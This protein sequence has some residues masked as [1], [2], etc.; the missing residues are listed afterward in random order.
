MLCSAAPLSRREKTVNNAAQLVR[1]IKSWGRELGFQQVGVTG[2][3]LGEA[4]GRLLEWLRRGY[5][6]E[7]NYMARHGA[8]RTR[9]A[10]LKPG[11]LTVISARMDYFPRKARAVAETLRDPAAAFISRYALGAD[12]HKLMR[13]RLQKLA[14]RIEKETGAFC[15]RAFTDSA[16][17]MEKPLAQKAG[18][19]WI[20]KHSN[21]INRHAGS[22]FFLGELYTDLKLPRDAPAADHCGTCDS[23]ITACPTGAI[24]AP[25]VV[26]ARKC[27][28]YL[29]IELKG[30]IPEPLRPL[31]GN[32]VFGCDDCQAVCPWNRFAQ[33]GGEHAFA[34][35]HGLDSAGLIALFAWSEEEFLRRT[36]GS[37]IRRI[38]YEQWLRNLAVALGNAPP[39]ATVTAALRSREN[40]PAPLV[41]EHVAWALL[42]TATCR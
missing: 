39:S 9:P 41:R 3:E 18:L 37:A 5:H 40:H 29:T 31:L 2:T 17:V 35:R 11:T 24:V 22:W 7:M 36:E 42:R 25:Y 15:H 32:R 26:D 21:L 38:G 6:G 27:I 20:G 30:A 13:R 19:G 4:E 16:P 23:C 33:A 1:Q 14:L 10:Q 8:K 28:S 34:P 12:Y